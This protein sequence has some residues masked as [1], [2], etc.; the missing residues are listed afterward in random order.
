MPEEI[1]RVVADL[2]SFGVPSAPARE[3]VALEFGFEF[4]DI[5]AIESL[6]ILQLGARA[7]R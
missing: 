6:G 4:D 5:R 2:L 1:N 7:W 3:G